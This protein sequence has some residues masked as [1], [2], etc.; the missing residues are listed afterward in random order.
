MKLARNFKK[1]CNINRQCK[2]NSERCYNLN[3]WLY[4]L[5]KSKNLDTEIIK[6]VFDSSMNKIHGPNYKNICPFYSYD[7]IYKEPIKIIKL[8]I[9]HTNINIIKERLLG[10]IDLIYCSCQEYVKELVEIYKYMKNSYCSKDKPVE[11][12][13]TCNELDKFKLS[14]NQYLYN[15]VNIRNKI[16]S[17]EDNKPVELLGCESDETILD[18]EQPETS[19]VSQQHVNIPTSQDDEMNISTSSMSSTVSTAVGTVAGASSILALLYKF[20]PGRKWIHSGFGGRRERIN[21]LYDAEPSE[22]LFDGQVHGDYGPY[23][24]R[25]DIG[26]SPI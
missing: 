10:N 16:P 21:N 19:Q 5:I 18:T 6:D 25:Y 23:N 20:T 13:Q 26:Y 1:F 3:N 12:D 8:N 22:L 24:Q 7:E 4:N 2:P 14:Y 15:D 11:N 9:F 17:L